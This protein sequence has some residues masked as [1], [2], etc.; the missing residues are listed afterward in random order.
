[1]GEGKA[2]QLSSVAFAGDIWKGEKIRCLYRL[3]LTTDTL[4]YSLLLQRQSAQTISIAGDAAGQ[5]QDGRLDRNVYFAKVKQVV[6]VHWHRMKFIG[7][8]TTVA[9]LLDCN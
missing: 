1:M 5:S 7:R 2:S 3:L 8:F 6:W 9:M 4:T